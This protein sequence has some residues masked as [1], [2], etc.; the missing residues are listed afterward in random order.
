MLGIIIL[1]YRTWDISVRCMQ[2]I[3]DAEP[4]LAYHIY[5]VDNASPVPMSETCADY[6][7]QHR[8]TVTFLQAEDNLGYA[9]GNNIGIRQAL[10]D[11]CG[12]LLITNN[13]IVFQKGSITQLQ[14]S[15]MAD[16]GSGKAGIAG[17]KVLGENGE[18]QTSR[19]SMHTGMKEIFQIFT[20][21]KKFFRSKWNKYYCLDQDPDEPADV[22]YVSGCC[23]MI[24]RECAGQVMPFD[25]GTVLYD[26]ELILGIRM[27]QAGY[28]T[29]YEP[30]SVVIHQHGGTTRQVQPFMYQCICQSELYYCS[31]YLHAK[32]WQLWLLYRYR[33]MLYRVRSLR[34]RGLRE[35]WGGFSAGT[36]EMYAKIWKE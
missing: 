18:I 21:G 17:P 19:C 34:N 3:A 25:E 33:R 26:E 36:A 14:Q 29:K 27:E 13:D 4:Q 22:Y 31:R 16:D 7:E 8:D 6:I 32:K 23:F 11:Q 2:S 9:A 35:Y 1:N 24:T 10:A 5:L 20:I 30:Q 28:R 15:L 12:Y